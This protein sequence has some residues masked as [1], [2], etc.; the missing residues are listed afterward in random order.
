MKGLLSGLENRCLCYLTSH[1]SALCSG[2][3]ASPL[4]FLFFPTSRNW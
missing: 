1:R 2:S 4:T 3:V